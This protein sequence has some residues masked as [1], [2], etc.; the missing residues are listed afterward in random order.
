ML[1]FSCRVTQRLA[2]VLP[3]RTFFS[4]F[5]PHALPAHCSRRKT[6]E[7]RAFCATNAN[8]F[9]RWIVDRGGAKRAGDVAAEVAVDAPPSAAAKLSRLSRVQTWQ[10]R[11]SMPL[12]VNHLRRISAK[13]GIFSREK[14]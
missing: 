6:P 9:Q 14:L 1:H 10:I 12:W 7:K 5:S 2:T 4:G 13:R 3:R 8:Q 11:S